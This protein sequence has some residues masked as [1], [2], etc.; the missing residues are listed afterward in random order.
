M[1]INYSNYSL[2]DGALNYS[3]MPAA[4]SSAG[5]SSG[6]GFNAG[7]LGAIGGLFAAIGSGASAF[8]AAESKKSALE[9]QA[10][11]AQINARIAEHQA[12]D[13]MDVAKKEAG[14]VSMRAGKVKSAQK[15]SQAARGVQIGVGNAAEEIATTDLMKEIDMLTINSNAV[16][17]AAA[18]RMQKVGFSNQAVID[19]SSAGSISSLGNGLSSFV[20]SAS[21]VAPTWYAAMKGR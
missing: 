19:R 15:V 6:F 17:Q 3:S 7:S 8:Y 11:M 4:T 5:S 10:D 12:Q 1:S 18:V 14:N 16:N 20:G 9:F 13:I 2:L 21:A